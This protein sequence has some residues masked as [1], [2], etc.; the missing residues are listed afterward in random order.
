[1]LHVGNMVEPPM[2]NMAIFKNP[3][4]MA[5]SIFSQKKPLYMSQG[6]LF[7]VVRVWNFAQKGKIG[8]CKVINNQ[9]WIV[10]KQ[11]IF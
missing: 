2:E 3:H 5:S 7:F 9:F 11:N 4:N 1:M 8:T 6:L 10:K